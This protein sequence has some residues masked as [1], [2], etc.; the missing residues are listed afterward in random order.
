M[1]KQKLSLKAAAAKKKRDLAYAMTPERR[2]K[3][4]HAQRMRNKAGSK[5]NGMDWDHKDQRWEMPSK[6][7]GNDGNG[8][9]KESGKKYKFK[10][11]KK[12]K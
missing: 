2:K 3:K 10:A 8:T 6:N 11:Y 1:P 5:A 4:A 7:R 9:K 12:T